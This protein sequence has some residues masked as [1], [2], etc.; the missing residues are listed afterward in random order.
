MDIR[1]IADQGNVD[2]AN[3]R[4]DRAKTVVIHPPA[5]ALND[6]DHATISTSGRDTLAA[7]EGLAE[8]ARKQGGERQEI[9]DAARARLESGALSSPDVLDRTARNI[10]DSG[11]LAG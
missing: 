2:R 9:V 7:V 3:D 5:P 11:F 1:N 8:R 4:A 6:Q 10:L